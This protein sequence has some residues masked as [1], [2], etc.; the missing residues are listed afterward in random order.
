[1][2][3]CV[4]KKNRCCCLKNVSHNLVLLLSPFFLL[5]LL[6]NYRLCEVWHPLH[7]LALPTWIF[8]QSVI[9][10]WNW[11]C[12]GRNCIFCGVFVATERC[13]L[14]TI[15]RRK[16]YNFST[17]L[18]GNVK[19]NKKERR[20][21]REGEWEGEKKPTYGGTTGVNTQTAVWGP[22]RIWRAK[23]ESQLLL[24]S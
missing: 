23:R 21:S 1:M 14:G 20:I 15:I 17:F 3:P 2:G 6:V 7:F 11:T 8:I 10:F 4:L 13:E 16:I 18:M 22:Q 12:S 24:R 5:R 9:S 19:R